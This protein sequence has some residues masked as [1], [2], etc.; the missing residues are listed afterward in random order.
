MESIK[1]GIKISLFVTIKLLTKDFCGV[2]YKANDNR[3]SNLLYSN[4]IIN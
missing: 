3:D 2:E 1:N 4:F